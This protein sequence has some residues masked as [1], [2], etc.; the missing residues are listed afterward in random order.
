[1]ELS[2]IKERM[3][4]V[5]TEERPGSAGRVERI[6]YPF[7]GLIGPFAVVKF[8]SDGP[9]KYLKPTDIRQAAMHEIPVGMA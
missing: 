8:G 7:K 2:A 5:Q 1:M 4:V 3:W 9:T 6:A